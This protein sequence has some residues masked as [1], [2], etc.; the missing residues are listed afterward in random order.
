MCFTER[1]IPALCVTILSV[2]TLLLG[3]ILLVMSITYYL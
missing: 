2:F 3:F 1:R